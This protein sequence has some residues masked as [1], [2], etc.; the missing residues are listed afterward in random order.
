M[1]GCCPM[2]LSV[3]RIID[4][5]PEEL[6]HCQ[7]G[8]SRNTSRFAAEFLRNKQLAL[9]ADGSRQAFPSSFGEQTR[10]IAAKMSAK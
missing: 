10:P 2:F 9:V 6:H 1:E 5:C 4:R 3:R 8:L 7:S